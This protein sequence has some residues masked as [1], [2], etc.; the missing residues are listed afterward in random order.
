MRMIRSGIAAPAAILSVALAAGLAAPAQAQ[1]RTLADALA[2]AYSTNPTLLTER[3]RLRAT[4]ENVPQALAGW[5]PTVTL[6]GSVGYLGN[7]SLQQGPVSLGTNRD[8]L[9][10]QAQISQPLYTGGKTSANVHKAENQVLSERATLINTEQTVFYN[11]VN[12]FVTVIEDQELVALQV[13]N[14]QVLTR[15]LQA[16]NDRFRVGEITRT[17]VAQAEASLASAVAQQRTAEGTLAA[18]RASYREYVGYDAVNL[19]PPQ[20]LALPIKSEKEANDLAAVNN[21]NVI[22]AAFSDAAARDAVD[23]AFAA[24][25]PTVSLQGIATRQDNST[26]RDTR[27]SGEEVLLSLT[28]PIYQGGSEYS[29]VRQARQSEQQARKTLD[30]QRRQAVQAASQAWENL[31][32]SRSTIVSDQAAIRADEI[33]L[34]GVEREALLGSRTTLDVLNAEQTLLQA[35]TTLVQN[36]ASLVIYS[37]QVAQATGRLTAHDLNLPVNYYDETAYY[38][39]VRNRLFG[40]NDYATTQ[41]GR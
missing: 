18:A 27:S 23:V 30:D 17:D 29:A 13:S 40:T 2:A 41:P 11:T 9:N 31:V 28:V 22:A 24:L 38:K 6:S 39:A 25:M 3:A 12:A 20:P 36:L 14:V 21:P 33:A 26:E 4:D 10:E 16:T 19:V 35:R 8:L 7:S 15:Q 37:F 34:D 32:A 5:R 1:P